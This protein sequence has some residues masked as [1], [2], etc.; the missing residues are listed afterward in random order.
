MGSSFR[1][2]SIRLRSVHKGDVVQS[3]VEGLP[4][5]LSNSSVAALNSSSTLLIGMFLNNATQVA[6]WSL[7][8]TGINAVLSLYNPIAN[9][10]YPHMVHSRDYRLFKWLFITGTLAAL[11]GSFLFAALSDT[12]MSIL[13][14]SD[15]IAGSYI[16]RLLSP[17]LVFAYPALLLG[18]PFLGAIGDGKEL[19]SSSLIT[20]LV[21][22]GCLL[23]LQLFG[24]FTI[25]SVCI[26][27][28]GA[29]ALMLIVRA[30][31]SVR[32][33]RIKS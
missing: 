22:I 7:A 20:A 23:A 17:V 2:T 3:Y 29:E 32:L 21:Y 15:Y 25:V 14:G 31:Y 27:R 30:F 5:F 10:L 33:F 24:V 28:C 19:A 8:V 16:L 11:V 26:C 1:T 4:F 12:A 9:A 6:Y 13:G 18:G